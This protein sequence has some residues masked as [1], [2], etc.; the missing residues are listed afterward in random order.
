MLTWKKTIITSM[1]IGAS[2]YGGLSYAR[3]IPGV[4]EPFDPGNYWSLVSISWP[5]SAP[6]TYTLRDISRNGGKVYDPWR[7]KEQQAKNAKVESW[8]Q[9]QIQQTLNKILSMTPWG[10]AVTGSLNDGIR[11]LHEKNNSELPA[12]VVRAQEDPK[13]F[14]T[15]SKPIGPNEDGSSP[16]VSDSDK[17]RYMRDRIEQSAAF[18]SQQQDASKETLELLEKALDMATHA[19]SFVEAQQAENI[20][21]ALETEEWN[22]R[23]AILAEIATLKSLESMQQVDNV[24]KAQQINNANK[25]YMYDPYNPTKVDQESYKRPEPMGMLDF[26]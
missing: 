5:D 15:P 4:D 24:V 13:L 26:K 3:I 14:A 25:L 23:N 22:R 17:I 2:L 21:K 9:A 1:I 10:Q 12:E 20:I 18:I 8:L 16:Y 11:I 19:E 6:S 7:D